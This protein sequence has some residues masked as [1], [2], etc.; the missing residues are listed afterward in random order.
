MK[1]ESLMAVPETAD[2][3]RAAVRALR[4]LDASKG[5]SSIPS[6]YQKIAALDFS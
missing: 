5:V 6:H 4:W 2:N 1:G 3:F